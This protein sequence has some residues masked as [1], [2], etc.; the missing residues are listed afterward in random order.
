MVLHKMNGLSETGGLYQNVWG[1]QSKTN[2][3]YQRV[4]TSGY[5]FIAITKTW[6][7]DGIYPRELFTDNYNVYRKDETK[8]LKEKLEE[9]EQFWPCPVLLIPREFLCV[10]YWILSATIKIWVHSNN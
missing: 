5:Y 1:V 9:G 7:H 8:L 4:S 2:E 3:L 10:G 6:L